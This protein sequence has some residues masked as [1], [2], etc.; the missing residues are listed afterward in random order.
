M[1]GTFV[2]TDYDVVGA[3]WTPAL[4]LENDIVTIYVAKTP[5]N[6]GV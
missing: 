4:D 2:A 1:E 5:A 3:D 6:P